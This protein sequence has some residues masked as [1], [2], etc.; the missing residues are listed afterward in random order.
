M[1]TAHKGYA[2]PA[3]APR[4]RTRTAEARGRTVARRAERAARHTP[5]PL[6]LAALA[7]E[8]G[9]TVGTVAR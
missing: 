6:D 5:A 7:A 4:D 9:A 2:A 3:P 8:I 1:S